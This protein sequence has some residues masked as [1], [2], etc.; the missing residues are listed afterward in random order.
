MIRRVQDI[1]S[2]GVSDCYGSVK[3][4]SSLG[5]ASGAA[6]STSEDVKGQ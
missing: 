4:W 2:E 1:T 6:V 5:K 3:T